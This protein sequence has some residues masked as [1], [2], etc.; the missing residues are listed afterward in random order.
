MTLM[1]PAHSSGDFCV[2]PHR[3]GLNRKFANNG[4]RWQN[5]EKLSAGRL[6]S[7]ST[8]HLMESTRHEL[9]YFVQ[10]ACYCAMHQTRIGVM[11]RSRKG[12]NWE[13]IRSCHPT[14]A[15]VM[16]LKTC[17]VKTGGHWD[18]CFGKMMMVPYLIVTKTDTL[19]LP[20]YTC[21]GT[22]RIR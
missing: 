19:R 8:R 9:A 10:C 6:R 11:K 2:S 15:A 20:D 12:G 13:S 18:K 14:V 3:Q 22:S 4:R 1:C 7:H 21:V 5:I 17:K 16:H